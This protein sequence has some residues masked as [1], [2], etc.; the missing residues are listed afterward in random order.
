MKLLKILLLLSTSIL[1]V[2]CEKEKEDETNRELEMFLLRTAFQ[3]KGIVLEEEVNWVFSNW[4]NGI[5]AY[6]ESFWCLTADKKIQQRNFAIYDYEGRGEILSIK[7]KSPA[8]SIDSSFVYKKSIFDLGVKNI[9]NPEDEIYDGFDIEVASTYGFF[10]TFYGN[11]NSSSLEVLKLEEIEPLEGEEDCK[12]V[13]VWFHFSCNLYKPNA[14]FAGK[15]EK[16][17]L[18]ASFLIENNG[19]FEDDKDVVAQNKN[20]C[21]CKLQKVK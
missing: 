16:G 8:F 15:I 4:Q 12:E 1:F 17:M 14:E 19:N 20:D 6:S 21:S 5:G 3:F 7:I 2:S 9:R 13:K 18:I 11:Q 10:S